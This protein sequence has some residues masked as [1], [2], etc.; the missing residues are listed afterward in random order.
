M[1]IPYD[2]TRTMQNLLITDVRRLGR[3]MPGGAIVFGDQTLAV[4]WLPRPIRAV[5][6]K[7]PIDKLIVDELELIARL[8]HDIVT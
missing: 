3:C 1:Q 7:R 4:Q 5:G 6:N 2:S 8:K